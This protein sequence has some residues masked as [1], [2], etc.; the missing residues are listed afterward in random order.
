MVIFLFAWVILGLKELFKRAMRKVY[1][2]DTTLR[3]GEQ[4]AHSAMTKTEKFEIARQL[5]R[6]G[7][8]VIEAGFP[9]S[10]QGDFEAVKKI[11]QE[12]KSPTI[13]ALSRALPGED[14]DI[15]RAW[16]AIKY[17]PK[18]RLHTFIATSPIHMKY[19]FKMDA[20]EIYDMALEA[21][22]YAKKIMGGRGEVEFSPEDATRS[23]PNFL[24][25]VIEGT[26]EEGA[27][28]INIP[29][30][31]GYATTKEFDVLVG[32]IQAN[33][34]NIDKVILSVHCHDD[35]G[36]AVSNSLYVAENRGVQQIECTINGIGERA[37]NAA[38]EEIVAGVKTRSDS[39]NLYTK[40]NT[41]EIGKTSRLVSRLTGIPVQPNKAVVG[42]N[43]FSHSA[44]IHQDGVTKRIETYEI[45]DVS[46]YGWVGDKIIIGPRA[47]RKG[48]GERYKMLGFELT[49]EELEKATKLV[50]QLADRDKEVFDDDLI[51]ILQDEVWKNPE[52]FKLVSCVVV[53]ES[54]DKL[55]SKANI[56]LEKDGEII[57]QEAY[58]NGPVSSIY[59][60]ID[61]AT[62]VKVKLLDYSLKS[63]TRGRDAIGE[64][65][66]K[67]QDHGST[68]IGRGSSMSIL[69][70]S[71]K[72]YL[73]A[74]NKAFTGRNYR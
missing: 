22:R 71:A 66:I 49:E 63:I 73:N 20:E 38:L 13:C 64:V 58:S 12:V 47:G 31:V 37:G 50:K 39:Y 16:E 9:I 52:I 48:I 68:Y 7:V 41:K 69:E 30:T 53:D 72:A 32:G 10:S 15:H 57:E 21:V 6:L 43:A 34:P 4:A 26:I 74:L 44:G 45:M 17:S 35:L 46:D 24:Y 19:K 60:A 56:K 28:I 59:K 67:L 62:G 29:D 11:A 8:D 51:V 25:R 18:P 55:K 3:D 70:A 5:E 27:D 36:L 61:M 23:E 65:T 33:V 40:I 1:I 54:G 42:E 14:M 2:F